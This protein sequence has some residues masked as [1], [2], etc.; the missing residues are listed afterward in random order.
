[1]S[2]YLPV[3]RGLAKQ[4][5]FS[6]LAIVTLALGIGVNVGIFSAL[7]AL[8]LEPLPYP[9]SHRLVTIYEDASWL[10]YAKN[11]PA[12]ANFVDWKREARSFAGMGATAGCRATLT[13]GSQPEEIR[14]SS[15]TPNLLPLLGTK[16][17]L[18]R[19]FE[20][21]E[22]V[23]DPSS[24]L[25]SEGLWQRRFGADRNIVG[26]T[27]QLNGRA[28]SIRGVMPDSFRFPQADVELWMP[29]GL[30]PQRWNSRSSH[31]LSVY[32]RLAPGVSLGEATQEL[33]A[34]Q[35]RINQRHPDDC[36]PRM[37][38]MIETL[39]DRLLGKTQLAL[40]ILMGA[41]AMVLLIACANVANLLLTRATGRQRELAIRSAL[42]A[43]T[44][45]L[46]EV[47]FAETLA[48]T[49]AGG[50]GGI[51][52]AAASRGALET[53][54]P[55]SMLGAV[56]IG[57]DG[58]VLLF[59]LLASFLAAVL[60]SLTP[61]LHIL[62]APLVNLLRQDS[63]AS[64]ARSTVTLRNVLVVGEVALTVTLLAGAALMTRSLIEIWNAPLGFDPGNLYSIRVS[65]SS[66]RYLESTKR[67]ELYQRSME[68][69]RALPGMEQVSFASTPPFFSHGNS[70]GYAVEGITP[71]GRAEN[72]DILVR[73]ATTNYLPMIG[74]KL[75]E[76]RFFTEADRAGAQPVAIVNEFFSRRHFNGKSPLGKRIC[77][78]PGAPNPVWRT[79]VGVVAEIRERGYD[80]NPKQVVYTS[81]S[82]METWTCS[83]MLVRGKNIP[84][85][86]PAIRR[87]ILDIDPDQ[88]IGRVQSFDDLLAIDQASRRQQ[89]F[90]LAAFSGLSLL[91]ACLGIYALL[92]YSIEL[93]RNE[94]G[95]R[96]AIGATGADLLKLVV[97]QGMRLALAG[98]ALGLCGA[99]LLGRWLE[100]SLYGV[101]PFDP[102]SLTIVCGILL[103]TALLACLEPALRA[104]R[105]SYFWQF[106]Q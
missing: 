16:P 75:K 45:A 3:L 11:T 80:L 24:V 49:L 46:M 36:D 41:S 2:R 59:S 25:I 15:L 33:R 72:E 78:T 69:I 55:E 82:Q 97:G 56:Y 61:L 17:L 88:P 73:N 28:V 65:Q 74:A 71:A 64:S 20:D 38:V 8:V 104:A 87:A 103:L 13:G 21:S 60:A 92:S 29:A 100:S 66:P 14:C 67:E 85:S 39:R 79:I 54:I 48:L 53:F 102:L 96:V 81:S 106:A 90:L 42:G 57:L 50:L 31:F 68:A 47:I 99:L 5:M 12:P 51:A 10:G 62:G 34:I 105:R 77:L 43:S 44:A 30:T 76:G 6:I 4:P 98:T 63:R 58:R 23:P 27:I 93:R 18:G 91:L 1:M 95:V 40:W 84:A 83:M 86:V 19:W 52:L 101:K 32:G 7:E 37:S 70:N 26:K 94:L 35:K 22:D 9:E 89:M